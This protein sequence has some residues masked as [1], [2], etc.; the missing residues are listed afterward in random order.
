MHNR[1]TNIIENDIGSGNN[2]GSQMYVSYQGETILDLAVG[3]E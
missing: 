3:C 2:L 1:I